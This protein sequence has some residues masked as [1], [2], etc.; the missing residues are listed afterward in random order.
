MEENVKLPAVPMVGHVN[1]HCLTLLTMPV[2]LSF[3]HHSEV[4]TSD[5]TIQMR[6]SVL[7]VNIGWRILVL[8]SGC[9]YPR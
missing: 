7:S 8:Y 1:S 3:Y 2:H 4:A 9:G 6:Y 5:L